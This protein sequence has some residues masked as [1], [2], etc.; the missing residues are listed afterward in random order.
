MFDRVG[1]KLSHFRS[2]TEPYSE[3]YAG[4]SEE[5]LSRALR[6][7]RAT[8]GSTSIFFVEDTSLRIEALSTRTADYPGLAVKEWFAKT[9]FAQLDSEIQRMGGQRAAIVK[10]DVGLHLPGLRR[11]IFF[12]G[13]TPGTVALAPPTFAPSLQYPWLVPTTFN[14]WFVPDGTLKRLGEMSFEESWAVDFRIRSL[15]RLVDRLEEYASVLNLSGQ[16]YSRRRETTGIAGQ[17]SLLPDNVPVF[18]VVGRTCAGKT[19]FGERAS[20][21]H[22]LR[23]IE[24]SSIVRM[25]SDEYE[26]GPRDAFL[27]ARKV[28]QDRGPDVVARK[29]LQLFETG[30]ES[31]VVVMG[32]RAIEE[33]ETIK[34]QYPGATV[35]LIEA[36][37]RI[38]YE[39]HLARGRTSEPSTLEAFRHNDEQQW[40]FGLLRIAEDFADVRILNEG[41]LEEYWAQVDAVVSRHRD[42]LPPGVSLSVRPRHALEQNQL[43]RTLAVLAHANRP[44][45]TE[46]I[47][48]ETRAG[49]QPIRHNNVNKVLRRV[50]ELARRLELPHNRLRYEITNAGRAYIRLAESVFIGAKHHGG[51]AQD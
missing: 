34:A 8:V 14:G 47:A 20:N 45:T 7:V 30:F 10:S 26:A 32:F 49:G 43:Y 1:L 27:L 11:P 35:I 25:L 41:G 28:L 2:R 19:T 48:I 18:I 22:A 40:Q 33:L 15:L 39:R 46:E 9:T 5:L 12:H 4:T 50:P 17:L 6:D 29:I 38:R 51:Q 42:Q 31:G 3:D 36:A 23:F 44:L 13:E 37:E 24:A 21:K 16:A